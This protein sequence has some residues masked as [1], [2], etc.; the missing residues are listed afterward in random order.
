MIA[1]ALLIGAFS[2]ESANPQGCP[3]GQ[4]AHGRCMKGSPETGNG[5]RQTY[6]TELPKR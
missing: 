5:L 1:L 4:Y 3:N 6:R 2:A